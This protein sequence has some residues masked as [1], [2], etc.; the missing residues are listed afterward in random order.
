MIGRAVVVNLQIKSG[1][2]NLHGAASSSIARRVRRNNFFNNRAGRAKPDFKQNQFGARSAARSWRIEHSSSGLSGPP[3]D[4]R[5][6]GPL[7]GAIEGMRAGDFSELSRIIYDPQTGQPFFRN[8]FR[9]PVS[10]ASRA[11]SSRSCIPAEHRWHPPGNGQ[12][13]SNYLLNPIRSGRTTIRR[14]GRTQAGNQ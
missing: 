4:A 11:P 5:P 7:H 12:P 6:D 8:V 3:R 9:T 13:I 10:T 14:E 1:T 2:N